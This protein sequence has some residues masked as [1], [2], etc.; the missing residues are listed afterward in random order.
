MCAFVWVK[1][2]DQEKAFGLQ[3][4]IQPASDEEDSLSAYFVLFCLVSII[5]N[6]LSKSEIVF[7]S[8]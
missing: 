1:R 3:E 7:C 5:S 2:G 8:Q 4:G 6:W